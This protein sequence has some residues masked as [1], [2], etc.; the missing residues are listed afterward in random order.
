MARDIDTREN[1]IVWYKEEFGFTANTSA[2]L[3]YDVQMLKT[4]LTLS[5]LD[6]DTV[7]NFCKAVSKDTDQ[8]VAEVAMTRLKLVC[9]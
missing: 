3:Y 1:F 9:F 4:C 6:E 7:A 5:E 2:T 8:S